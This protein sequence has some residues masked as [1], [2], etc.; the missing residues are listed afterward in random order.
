M[1][2]KREGQAVSDLGTSLASL[3]SALVTS[4]ALFMLV[5]LI[6]VSVVGVL[7]FRKKPD[8]APLHTF[9]S[10]FKPFSLLSMGIVYT[11]IVLFDPWEAT[12]GNR[13]AA[14][15]LLEHAFVWVA[16]LF[17]ETSWYSQGWK[18]FA[19]AM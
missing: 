17:A 15:P 19:R 1:I 4:Q 13:R 18:A 8:V 7:C 16:I 10:R 2:N 11:L 14:L 9:A 5:A 12:F 3:W 6:V